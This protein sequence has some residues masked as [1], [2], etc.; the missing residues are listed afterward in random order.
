MNAEEKIFTKFKINL[1]SKE[2]LFFNLYPNSD[3]NAFSHYVTTKRQNTKVDDSKQVDPKVDVSDDIADIKVNQ[4]NDSED[5]VD[6]RVNNNDD[7]Q[8]KKRL[9]KKIVACDCEMVLHF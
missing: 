4:H 5:I 9:H 2:Q 8:E 1:L 6:R 3:K 7:N